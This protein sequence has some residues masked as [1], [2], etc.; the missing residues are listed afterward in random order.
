MIEKALCAVN[1]LRTLAPGLIDIENCQSRGRGFK[2][3]RA[4]H[5]KIGLKLAASLLWA[6][7]SFRVFL[8]PSVLISLFPAVFGTWMAH[9]TMTGAGTPAE[10]HV[11]TEWRN[12]ILHVRLIAGEEIGPMTSR[13]R[14]EDVGQPCRRS[15]GG[16]SPRS[17]RRAATR[18]PAPSPSLSRSL[19]P[20]SEVGPNVGATRHSATRE[21]SLSP[22]SREV[23]KRSCTREAPGATRHRT[24][25]ED[26][27]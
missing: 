2:S 18:R 10:A 9:A 5:S 3:R 22:S 19:N 25:K 24:H 13:Q 1:L 15:T 7:F 6:V 8:S 21:R 17:R 23:Y 16:P 12:K 26:P 4:R 20:P 27:S 14:N 11:P